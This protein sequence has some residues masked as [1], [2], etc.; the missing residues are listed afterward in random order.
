MILCFIV[1][2]RSPELAVASRIPAAA[3][4]EIFVVA[5]L[6]LSFVRSLV[7]SFVRLFVHLIFS[8]G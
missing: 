8:R 2:V 4:P 6:F 7:R 1:T 3:R 5:D